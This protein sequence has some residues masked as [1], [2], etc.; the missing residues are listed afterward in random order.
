MEVELKAYKNFLTD[1]GVS[2][3]N[4]LD[5]LIR[6][7]EPWRF[8]HGE[9]HLVTFLREIRKMGLDHQTDIEYVF[10][11][12]FHDAVYLP[13]AND[14]EEKSLELMKQYCT[15]LDK[16]TLE[17]VERLIMVTKERAMPEDEYLKTFWCID[18]GILLNPDSAKLMEYEV[19]IRKEF[20]CCD[21]S[22]YREGR[23]DFL[24]NWAFANQKNVTKDVIVKLDMLGAY[25][26]DYRPKI[27]VYAGSFNPLHNGHLNII[28]KAEEVFDKVIVALGQNPEKSTN[29]NDKR[30]KEVQNAVIYRQVDT[31]NGLLT[32]YLES[33]Q[34]TADTYLVRG[35]RN[36]DDLAYEQNQIWF[37]NKLSND[38]PRVV[39]FLC[40]E[41]F[42]H[43]S[44]SAIR[45]LL[46][47]QDDKTKE[48]VS[49]MIPEGNS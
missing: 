20:Q 9:N 36:G 23:M 21:Y 44:S 19:Q 18:N 47:I 22:L 25:V 49:E 27:G 46:K 5:V 12:I 40:D 1:F 48:L 26:R 17:N 31:F 37:M 33:K 41:G 2:D 35:L 39:C 15:G 32:D 34:E 11:A 3:K 38:N 10:A 30:L 43:I 4:A 14:N 24:K 28:E 42:E 13:W 8:W 45:S 6:W 29:D 16:E 7:Y